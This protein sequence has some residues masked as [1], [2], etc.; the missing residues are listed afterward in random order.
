MI[1][2]LGVLLS[3]GLLDKKSTYFILAS[4]FFLAVREVTSIAFDTM[5]VLSEMF[6]QS[7]LVQVVQLLSTVLLLRLDDRNWHKLCDGLL[8]LVAA[9]VIS[10]RLQRL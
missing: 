8:L 7:S 5:A 9:I 2:G 4:E 1:V 10:L 3:D 6:A